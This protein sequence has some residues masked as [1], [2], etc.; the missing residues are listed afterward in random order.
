MYEEIRKYLINLGVN[1]DVAEMIINSSFK[2]V[3]ISNFTIY[4]NNEKL[5]AFLKLKNLMTIQPF[6]SFHFHK[7]Y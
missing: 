6:Q 7:F 1:K 2:F 4:L 3:A 5:T